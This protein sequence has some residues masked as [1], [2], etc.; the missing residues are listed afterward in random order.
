MSL[1]CPCIDVLHFSSILQSLDKV[2][3]EMLLESLLGVADG[4]V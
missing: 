3:D 4:Y 2:V 1:I